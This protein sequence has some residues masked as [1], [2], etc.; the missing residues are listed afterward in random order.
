MIWKV[1]KDSV[2]FKQ[3]Y[4]IAKWFTV[5]DYHTLEAMFL[6]TTIE[7]NKETLSLFCELGI[8]SE[9]HFAWK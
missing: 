6:L 2:V 4:F 7:K 9:Y 5:V 8:S 1:R 3:R